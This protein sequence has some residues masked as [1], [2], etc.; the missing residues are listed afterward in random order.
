MTIIDFATDP[1]LLNLSLSD[2][3]RTVL[4]AFYGE[5]LGDAEAAMF[6]ELAG[7]PYEQEPHSELTCIAGARSGKDSRIALAIA[8][9]E[10]FGRDHSYLAPGEKGYVL[11]VAQDQRGGQIALGYIRAAIEGSDLLRSQV[12]ETRKLEIELKNNLVIAVYPCSYRAPRGIT[13]LCGIADEVAFWRDENSSNSDVEIIRTMRRGMANVPDAKLVRIST[14]YAKAGVL[15]DDFRRRHELPEV[16]V[17]QAPTW[18]MN[19]SISERFLERERDKDPEAYQREYGAQFSDSISSFLSREAIDACVVEGRR[20]LPPV[21]RITYSAFVDPS[22]GSKDSMTLAISH[23]D[24]GRVVLDLV[25]ERKPPFSPEAVVQEFADVLKSYRSSTVAGDRYAGEWPRERFRVH[26]INYKIA[27]KN[28][29]ELYLELLPVVNSQTVELLD[30]QRLVSQ[31]VGL[32]RRT[33]RA[34]KD[35]VD[36]GPGAHDDLANAAAGALT[37]VD[38]RVRWGPVYERGEEKPSPEEYFYE[39]S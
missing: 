24:A 17:V 28:R 11:I 23:R 13:V 19:P 16:L 32:E 25:R 26:G 27:E 12:L 38:R 33:S 37:L 4:K 9:Y 6:E 39:I 20:E 2:A 29:S 34:G 18:V 3:Q 15:W 35:S 8:L 30:N 5:P 14:P 31:L 21:E 10:A 22:G 1:G 36:H 7:R